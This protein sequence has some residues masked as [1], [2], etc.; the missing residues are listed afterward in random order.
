MAGSSPARTE[1]GINWATPFEPGMFS[2]TGSSRTRGSPS[3]PVASRP[4]LATD[5]A[6]GTAP[7]RSHRPG[8]P[9][10]L[11]D[12]RLDTGRDLVHIEFPALC[13]QTEQRL[14]QPVEVV[15]RS[16]RTEPG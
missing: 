15:V 9:G 10:H 2:S 11:H 14:P 12:R 4:R 3:P 6:E 1:P 13:G 16:V 7:G 5:G 8:P